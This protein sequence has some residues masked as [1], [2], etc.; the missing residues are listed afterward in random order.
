V[1]VLPLPWPTL[2]A[3]LAGFRSRRNLVNTS[4]QEMSHSNNFIVREVALGDRLLESLAE[5][6]KL[7]IGP[8]DE[9]R[10]FP[11]RIQRMQ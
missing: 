11:G 1:Q 2:F 10:I 6:H 4:R 8:S 5:D 3:A 9:L 7:W